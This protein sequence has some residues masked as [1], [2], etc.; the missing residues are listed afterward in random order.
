MVSKHFH[1]HLVSDATGETVNL[2]ARASLVQFDNIEQTK[3]V[4]NMVRSES[5]IRDIIEGV[6]ENP[7]FVLYT[8]VDNEMRNLLENSCRELKVPCIPILDPVV[9]AL[10]S[11]LKAEIR[12]APGRQ[13][14]M[15]AEYFSRIEALH[16]VLSHDDGQA[17]RSLNEADVIIVGV[18]RTSKTPTCIYLANR[19]LKAAN[20]PIVPGCALPPELMQSKKPLVVG[21]TNDPRQLVQIR[22]NR[23]RSLG[24]DEETDYIDPE[25]VTREVKEAKRLYTSQ[26]WPVIDVTRKSIEEVSAKILQLYNRRL[27]QHS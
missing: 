4:W 6:K 13:H 26:G 3:H 18:S 17:T 1:L 7:G 15:D 8:L 16:F 9:S 19:G 10:G 24:Q 5:Q 21:L 12:A 11:Y 22:R 27:E 23:L 25:T 2:V 20:V 14:V